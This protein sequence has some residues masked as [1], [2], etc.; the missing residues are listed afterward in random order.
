MSSLTLEIWI[1]YLEKSI[2]IYIHTYIHVPIDRQSH[3][4]HKKKMVRGKKL[5]GVASTLKYIQI[6][7]FF[8]FNSILFIYFSNIYDNVLQ[9]SFI[10]RHSRFHVSMY[11]FINERTQLFMS[12]YIYIYV[13]YTWLLRLCSIVLSLFPLRTCSIHT[14]KHCH[15]FDT[16]TYFIVIHIPYTNE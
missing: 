2:Y 7:I 1:K 11:T 3:K 8:Y 6:L 16:L 12:L 14:F 4:G 10:D 13:H 9:E 15:I 5:R